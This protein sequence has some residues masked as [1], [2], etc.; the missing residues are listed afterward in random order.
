VRAFQRRVASLAM[1]GAIFSGRLFQ[2]ELQVCVRPHRGM[3]RSRIFAG[4]NY[5]WVVAF[6]LPRQVAF[7]KFIGSHAEYDRIDALTVSQF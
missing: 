2:V 5:R 6:D 7:V 4:G 3:T 1:D